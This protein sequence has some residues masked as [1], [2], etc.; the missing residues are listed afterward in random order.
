LK[1]ELVLLLLSGSTLSGEVQKK[2]SPTRGEEKNYEIAL[3][4]RARKKKE[5]SSP[6]GAEEIKEKSLLL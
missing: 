6:L 1:G 3:L 5:E 4:P 2:I